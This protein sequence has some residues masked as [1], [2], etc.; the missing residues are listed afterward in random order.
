[1]IKRRKTPTESI[2]SSGDPSVE[3]AFIKYPK[4]N[5]VDVSGEST[6]YSTYVS[7]KK[8][9]EAFGDKTFE[10][11]KKGVEMHTHPYKMDESGK[12]GQ[13]MVASGA[14]IS[15][16]FSNPKKIHMIAYRD[17]VKG[18]VGGYLILR[19]TKW[20][21]D[22]DEKERRAEGVQEYQ[23]NLRNVGSPGIDSP[24]N[25]RV[26]GNYNAGLQKSYD[27]A[28]K[29]AAETVGFRYKYI[30]AKG[31]EFDMEKGGLVKKVGLRSKQKVSK[32]EQTV[33]ASS[34]IS[35]FLSFLFLSSNMTGN[36]IADL[37]IRSSNFVGA[38]LFIIGIIAG[39]FWLKRK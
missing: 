6:A 28:L 4:Q 13:P 36:T 30:P 12:Y 37:S 35:L 31:Y 18:K 17:K 2:E 20:K 23:S 39:F 7:D 5:P 32:I 11:I 29:R 27:A 8:F 9:K 38:L 10:K 16:F 21:E 1:M 24:Y 25:I 14:D 22:F 26:K 15:N 3:H 19:K 34:F 33:L